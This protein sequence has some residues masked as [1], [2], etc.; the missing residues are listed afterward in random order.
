MVKKENSSETVKFEHTVKDILS[1]NRA[2]RDNPERPWM[3][4]AT[5]IK[6]YASSVIMN[7][8][9]K[10]CEDK[11]D[12]LIGNTT[13]D[14]S[15][16]YDIKSCKEAAELLAIIRKDPDAAHHAI[17]RILKQTFRG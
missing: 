5:D 3:G 9:R 8:I 11:L 10:E 2:K 4:T 12:V 1:E 15:H 13:G 16:T 14:G 6:G 17:I 7:R